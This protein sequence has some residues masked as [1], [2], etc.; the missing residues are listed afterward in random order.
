MIMLSD[1]GM[2]E[3][4]EGIFIVSSNTS[5]DVDEDLVLPKARVVG[6][7]DRSDS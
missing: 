1:E 5:K 7:A 6:I 3:G 2:N 4:T